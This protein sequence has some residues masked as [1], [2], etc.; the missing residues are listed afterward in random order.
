MEFKQYAK[1]M[2]NCNVL[3]KDTEQTNGYFRRFLIIPFE[4]TITEKEKDTNLAEKIA[5]KEMPG[6]FNW[7]LAGLDRLLK[8]NQF[9]YCEPAENALKSYKL[10]SDNVLQ[11]LSDNDYNYKSNH[12]TPLADLYQSYKNHCTDSGC[13]P[14][15]KRNFGNRLLAIG[16][17]RKRLTGGTVG[18]NVTKKTNS[19]LSD[20]SSDFIDNNESQ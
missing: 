7:V 6:I 19:D 13:N 11:F 9:T 10:D 14:L 16:S 15:N 8:N 20:F 1:L 12:F 3:P 5:K 2:F 17:K 18:F 4:R